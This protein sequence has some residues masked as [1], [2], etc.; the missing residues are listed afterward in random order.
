MAT[1]L[2]RPKALSISV[3]SR[4]NK[5]RISTV[6]HDESDHVLLIQVSRVASNIYFV[7]AMFCSRISSHSAMLDGTWNHSSAD[8]GSMSIASV[9]HPITHTPH[10]MHF[11]RST[12]DLKFS[13]SAMASTGQRSWQTPQAMHVSESMTAR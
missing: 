13:S 9:V 7:A 8:T 11:A 6:Y 10:P 4:W 12:L 3:F 5:S 1:L 2:L